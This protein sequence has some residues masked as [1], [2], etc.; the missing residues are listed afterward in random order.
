M[1]PPDQSSA[2][3]IAGRAQAAALDHPVRS[4]LLMAC[5]RQERCLTDLAREFGEPLPKLHYH[6]GRLT[7]C[8]LLRPS[9]T[10]P[11]AGRPIRYYRAVAEAFLISLADVAA[12]VGET[13]ARELRQSLAEQANRRDLSLLYHLD[14]A[15][16]MRVQL[17]DP[18]GRGRTSRA[19]EFW[20]VL[21][22]TAE[23]R[24][25]LGAELMAVFARYEASAPATS[26]EP[27]LVHAAFAPKLK[28][29]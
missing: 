10:E 24:V 13:L 5:A 19:F 6:L 21:R 8:G 7:G 11:R 2:H 25:A 18:D 20:K 26:G 28:T 17:I 1:E 15:G 4:R 12:P 27:F 23:Q 9:R 22:L 16:R 29:P 3:R 14:E